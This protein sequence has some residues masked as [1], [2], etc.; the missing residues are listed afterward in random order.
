MADRIAVKVTRHDGLP[1]SDMFMKELRDVMD[2]SGKK[3]VK[4][5]KQRLLRGGKSRKGKLYKTLSYKVDKDADLQIEAEHYAQYVDSGR[6]RG[7]WP[8][9]SAISDWVKRKKIRSPQYS[10]KSLVYL[11]GRK[12]FR[13]GI[14]PLPFI[15]KAIEKY[16]IK[17]ERE[18]GSIINR[19]KIFTKQAK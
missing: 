19:D 1:D 16:E 17:I 9:V 6:R 3:I 8:P 7:S 11:I 4:D 14:K 10:H 15:T 5:A 12:I 18:I 13:V 2:D